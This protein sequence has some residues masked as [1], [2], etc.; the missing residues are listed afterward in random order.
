MG[1]VSG[2]VAGVDAADDIEPSCEMDG[3]GVGLGGGYWVGLRARKAAAIDGSRLGRGGGATESSR[4]GRGGGATDSRRLGIIG[5]CCGCCCCCG[6]VVMGGV[7]AVVAGAPMA[8]VDD[9]DAPGVAGTGRDEVDGA[10]DTGAVNGDWYCDGGLVVV[11]VLVVVGAGEPIWIATCPTRAVG[12][13]VV[14]GTG[15]E[16]DPPRGREGRDADLAGRSAVPPAP[17]PPPIPAGVVTIAE[18]L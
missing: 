10:F 2:V 13:A 14:G 16:N 4:L 15:A 17:L 5:G 6:W 11:A 3:S 1:V 18:S 8:V 7:K 9:T 12:V